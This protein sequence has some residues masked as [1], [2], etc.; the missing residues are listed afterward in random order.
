[1]AEPFGI[2]T[3]ALSI[4]AL[5]N[6]CVDCFEYI[7]LGRNFGR[8][9]QTSQLK[10]DIAEVRLTRWGQSVKV[11]EDTNFAQVKQGNGTYISAKEI[12]EQLLML[13]WAAQKV[14]E[15]YKNKISTSPED[16][17]LV[18]STNDLDATFLGLHN[19][20]RDLSLR[21]QKKA[22][23]RQKTIW[24]LHDGKK[25]ATLVGQ[26]IDFIKEL[27]ELFPATA[28][29]QSLAIR[30]VEE[31]DDTPSLQALKEAAANVDELL[32]EAA[33]KKE[34]QILVMNLVKEAKISG[35]AKFRA[36]DEYSESGIASIA[37]I[38]GR[39]VGASNMVEKLEAGDNAAVHVGT[40]YG[41]KGVL[42]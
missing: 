2:V 11:Y 24:A 12:L 28:A 39:V 42:D 30:E 23:L 37:Q 16:M 8:D 25:F 29:R 13:F 36:G 31:V 38:K 27:E 9:Y 6:N 35:S 4:A 3:G 40:K 5:F 14:S 10:L 41:G 22:G 33:T 18:D 26:I 20:M 21:R 19:R 17:T 1:M 32:A 34:E 15:R 7:Q